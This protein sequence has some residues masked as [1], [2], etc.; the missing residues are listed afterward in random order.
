MKIPKQ[1]R[2]QARQLFR[3]CRPQ[4]LLEDTRV[5]A[6]VT[7]VLA[8]RPR[9]FEAVLAE[10]QRL[11]KLDLARRSARVESPAP[12]APEFQGRIKANLAQRYG[13]GL[14]IEFALNPALLGGLR[15]R[16]GSDVYDGSILARLSALEQAL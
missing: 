11:V 16:V 13:A 9:G 15:I 7:A 12:L 6:A 3:V 10:F 1:A 8:R 4:G 14:M 2:R 5:R